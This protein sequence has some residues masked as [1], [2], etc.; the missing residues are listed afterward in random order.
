[1]QH[2]LGYRGNSGHKQ[3]WFCMGSVSRLNA[4]PSTLAKFGKLFPN[5]QVG[6]K[7]QQR[8]TPK[9]GELKAKSTTGK[10]DS[11]LYTLRHFIGERQAASGQY[12]YGWNVGKKGEKAAVPNSGGSFS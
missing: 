11:C 9:I 1:M 3:S 12:C 5:E 6:L 7:S 8:W 10:A 2:V 4:L